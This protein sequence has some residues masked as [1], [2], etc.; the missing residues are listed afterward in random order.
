MTETDYEN[1]DLCECFDPIF[2][3]PDSFMRECK[4]YWL[5]EWKKDSSSIKFEDGSYIVTDDGKQYFVYGGIMI[6]VSEYFGSKKHIS[7]LI[8]EL[9]LY[10]IKNQRC[11]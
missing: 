5:S 9:V 10:K 4:K 2:I 8:E 11:P 3:P 7:E 6:K 1:I